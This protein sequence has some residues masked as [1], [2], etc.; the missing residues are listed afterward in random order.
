[1]TITLK[2]ELTCALERMHYTKYTDVQ[3]Q[4]IP[5]I[6]NGNDV[7]IQAPP[8]S[9]KTLAYVLP[10]LN[11]LELQ[12][13]GKHFPHVLILCPTRELC[14]QTSS[15]IRSVLEKIEG[16]RTAVLTGGVDIKVQ[17]RAFSRGA[18]IV[19]GTPS[20]ILDHLKR[21]TLKPKQ[22]TSVVIDEADEM[23]NMGFH[24][25]VLEVMSCMPAHQT[26]MLSATWKDSLKE[27]AEHLLKEP[28]HVEIHTEKVL[29]Q[30]IA[31]HLVSTPDSRK[32]ERLTSIVRKSRTQMIVFTNRKAT[33]DFVASKLSEAGFKA[34]A[35]HSDMDYR[36]RIHSMKNFR[37]GNLKILCATSVAS[38]GIDIPQVD[39]V[40][41]YDI[42]DTEEELVHRT[43]RTGRSGHA[44]DAWLLCNEK[45]KRKYRYE[46][47]FPS[48][49]FTKN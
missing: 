40:I 14:L 46:T 23:M 17:I 6:L 31:Y 36:R 45:E 35:V 21:H 28:V 16:Y 20:R 5:H 43:A 9:G 41:L 49:T 42:P 8:G 39:T 11:G 4:A 25:E 19:V 22:I 47:I 7:L 30:K 34:E 48:I 10:L 3:K 27:L 18:D 1:M 38:R 33:S 13:K 24:D 12:G 29:P 37:N 32:L 26:V 44:G 2:E 15:V